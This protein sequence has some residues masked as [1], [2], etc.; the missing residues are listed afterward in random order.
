ML[1]QTVMFLSVFLFAKEKGKYLFKSSG[2]GGCGKGL[3][4]V[5]DG[6]KT[7]EKCAQITLYLWQKR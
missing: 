7:L 2:D 6:A 5:L 1:R 4:S 3:F